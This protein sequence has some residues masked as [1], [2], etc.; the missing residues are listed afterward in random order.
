MDLQGNN[1]CQILRRLD[2]CIGVILA[3][4][5][6]CMIS[7]HCHYVN[8]LRVERTISQPFM[9]G[10]FIKCRERPVTFEVK[11]LVLLFDACY[12]HAVLH[13]QHPQTLIEFGFH[14]SDER[15][16]AWQRCCLT[17]HAP[18]LDAFEGNKLC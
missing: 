7:T 4:D 16:L 2:P 12:G 18:I 8:S 15:Q 13:P 14:C 6:P 1:R 11:P 10:P 3:F 9:L 5:E 17:H